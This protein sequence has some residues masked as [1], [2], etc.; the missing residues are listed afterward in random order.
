MAFTATIT[1][2]QPDSMPL[3]ESSG[4]ASAEDAYTAAAAHIH[5]AEPTDQIRAGD[6]GTYEVWSSTEAGRPPQL[7]A[8]LTITAAKD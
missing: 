5:T 3:W 8:T 7:V 4:H 1:D 6:D 2:L